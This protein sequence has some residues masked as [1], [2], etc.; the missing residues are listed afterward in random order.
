MWYNEKEVSVEDLVIDIFDAGSDDDDSEEEHDSD[1]SN[2]DD[3]EYD[4][5]LTVAERVA[6]ANE[7]N[8]DEAGPMETEVVDAEVVNAEVVSAE[9]VD[10]QV[11]NLGSSSDVES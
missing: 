11:I 9:V 3:D 8:D 5:A 6:I 4:I 2:N 10:V 1:P 7:T